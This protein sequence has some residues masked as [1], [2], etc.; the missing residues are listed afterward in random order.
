MWPRMDMSS[1]KTSTLSAERTQSNHIKY[2]INTIM[3]EMICLPTIMDRRDASL[4][5]LVVFSVTLFI[6]V[7][8]LVIW[9]LL[10]H[11]TLQSFFVY[12]CWTWV[13]AMLGR[14]RTGEIGSSLAFS[15]HS[16]IVSSVSRWCFKFW[17]G[18]N[19]LSDHV[20]FFDSVNGYHLFFIDN[21]IAS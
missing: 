6:I 12:S 19:M 18:T 3:Y 14:G 9:Y 2:N 11:C 16:T 1:L 21:E 20:E 10:L 4:F 8:L 5:C 15:P 13:G 7:F 17:S